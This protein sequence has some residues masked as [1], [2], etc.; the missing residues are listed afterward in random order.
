MYGRQNPKLNNASLVCARVLM[1]K[2]TRLGCLPCWAEHSISI[3]PR[4]G[5]NTA[6]DDTLAWNNKKRRGLTMIEVASFSQ[7]LYIILNARFRLIVGVNL[8]AQEYD[9]IPQ[10][11]ANIHCCCGNYRFFAIHTQCTNNPFDI[12]QYWSDYAYLISPPVGTKQ[13]RQEVL[14]FHH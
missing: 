11:S 2:H 13:T 10:P 3:Y 4:P 8:G 14:M 9:W 7:L 12:R 1:I 6:Q 5:K